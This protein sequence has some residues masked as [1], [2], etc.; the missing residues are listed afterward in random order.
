MVVEVSQWQKFSRFDFSY[1]EGS[2]LFFFFEVSLTD[3]QSS[4][5]CS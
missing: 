2:F 4:T 1:F 3:T 5:F